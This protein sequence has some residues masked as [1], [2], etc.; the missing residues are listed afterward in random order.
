LKAFLL[1][2]RKS[3]SPVESYYYNRYRVHWCKITPNSIWG[4]CTTL[5]FI[6]T[7]KL[8]YAKPTSWKSVQHKLSNHPWSMDF[9]AVWNIEAKQ[10]LTDGSPNWLQTL[11]RSIPEAVWEKIQDLARENVDHTTNHVCPQN[12]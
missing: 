2:E 12:L 3:S 8:T 6:P 9:D 7:T 1:G 11:Q 4:Y 10:Y 5:G